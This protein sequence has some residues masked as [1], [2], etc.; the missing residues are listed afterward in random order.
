MTVSIA[1]SVKAEQRSIP[2]DLL[3]W[4]CFGEH[5]ESRECVT[6]KA[7]E[8]RSGGYKSARSATISRV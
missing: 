7:V 6:Y 8:A 3:E 4:T 1:G 5:L 2:S